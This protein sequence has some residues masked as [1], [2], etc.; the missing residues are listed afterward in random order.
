MSNVTARNV[1][2]GKKTQTILKINLFFQKIHQKSNVKIEYFV[3]LLIEI[4]LTKSF[5][6]EL[7]SPPIAKSPIH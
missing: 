3:K 5:S 4:D 6:L 2:D 1:F 7:P